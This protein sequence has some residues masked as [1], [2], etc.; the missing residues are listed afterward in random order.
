MAGKSFTLCRDLGR[1]N[2]SLKSPFKLFGA[3]RFRRKR[4]VRWQAKPFRASI[5]LGR[6]RPHLACH[7]LLVDALLNS[8]VIGCGPRAV[9]PRP[10]QR[11]WSVSDAQR[12][13]NC[14][15]VIGPDDKSREFGPARGLGPSK[16]RTAMIPSPLRFFFRP[17]LSMQP[18]TDQVE[19]PLG[20]S[21]QVF[22]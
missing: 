16:S 13:P 3:V 15:W 6:P 5:G 7:R 12:L 2:L 22:T 10:V 19:V 9:K 14:L 4:D 8:R 1:H 17:S 11:W 21:C 20:T 18:W